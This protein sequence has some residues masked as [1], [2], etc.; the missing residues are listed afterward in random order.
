MSSR[1]FDLL[2]AAAIAGSELA[3]GLKPT[4]KE[5]HRDRSTVCCVVHL[6]KESERRNAKGDCIFNQSSW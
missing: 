2:G 3:A 6:L 5:H 4:P 1:K